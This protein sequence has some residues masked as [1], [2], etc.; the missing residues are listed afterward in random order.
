MLT[1]FL[2]DALVIT[3]AEF[4]ILVWNEAAE[5]LY[6]WTAAEVIGCNGVTLFKTEFPDLD[7]AAMLLAIREQG[8]FRGECVQSCKDGSRVHIE[9]DSTVLKGD[10]GAITGYLSIN[11]DITQRK[12]VEALVAAQKNFLTELTDNLP[13]L[14]GFWDKDERC[15]FANRHYR[16]W[17]GRDPKGL[18]G[19]HIR[20]LLGEEVY[21]KNLPYIRA[22]LAGESQIFERDLPN[23]EGGV[24]HCLAQ[25]VPHSQN[26]HILGFF[27]LVSDITKQKRIETELRQAKDA[28]ERASQAKGEFLAAMSHEIRT[29]MNGVLGMMHALGDTRLDAKQADLVKTMLQSGDLLLNVINDI[30]DFTKIEA[31]KLDVQIGEFAL[32][33]VLQEAME[34]FKVSVAAKGL[35]LTLE[36]SGLETALVR[37]DRARMKQVI[38]NLVGNAVKFTEAGTITLRMT[39]SEQALLVEVIDTGIGIPPDKFER[40]FQRFGQ[41]D[42]SASRQFGGTGLG[43]AI[44]KRLMEWMGGEI[45]F[46][47]T[48]GHGSNFWCRVPKVSGLVTT[49]PPALLPSQPARL[50]PS[51]PPPAANWVPAQAQLRVLLAED[52]VVNQKVAHHLLS[53]WH[54]LVDVACDGAEAV[55][56]AKAKAYDL[57][58]MDCQM[59][60]VDGFAA[61]RAIRAWEAETN[62]GNPVYIVAL[63][64]AV[65]SDERASCFEAG[66]NAFLA[67]PLKPDEIRDVIQSRVKQR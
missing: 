9:A 21:L 11:R 33:P 38:L 31:G 13:G 36:C 29:P 46:E 41:A 22:A 50:L 56:M 55:V 7:K 24:R 43:L 15:G 27:V 19:L 47:S 42:T 67:K 45:G 32:A 14:I 4:R 26:G 48:F 12:Q 3:D 58:F 18:I 37:A 65:M 64:A 61:T 1:R 54:C 57:I 8:Y 49:F 62:P 63:T 5:K 66:M 30:L 23:P 51:E 35:A 44:S 16:E 60:K 40:I 2:R 52:N 34:T 10:D 6:G 53:K 17:F 20:E 28:A 25:Y 59:P 39:D